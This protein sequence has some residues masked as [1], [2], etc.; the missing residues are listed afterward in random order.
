[1]SEQIET[2]VTMLGHQLADEDLALVVGGDDTGPGG[3]GDN[4]GAR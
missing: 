2:P 1:M 3:P 4:T